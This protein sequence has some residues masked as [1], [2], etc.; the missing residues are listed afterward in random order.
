MTPTLTRQSNNPF[1]ILS[2]DDDEIDLTTN[3]AAH[4]QAMQLPN[5]V[6]MTMSEAPQQHPHTTTR[7]NSAL[8]DSGATSHFL[9]QGAH[10]INIKMDNDPITITLP[11]GRA[12]QSTHTCN[13]DIPWLR[14]EATQAHIVPGQ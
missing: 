2:D 1:D 8:S 6:A 10:A 14:S 13:L 7:C 4:K 5:T 3:D 12:I 9:V 11:D